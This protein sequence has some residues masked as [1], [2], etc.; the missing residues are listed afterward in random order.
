MAWSVA[1]TM[2][3]ATAKRNLSV[4]PNI[5]HK[6]DLDVIVKHTYLRTDRSYSASRGLLSPSRMPTD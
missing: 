5:F 6:L 2:D 4:A 3:N 1:L